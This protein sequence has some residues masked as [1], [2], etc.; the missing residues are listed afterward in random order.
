MAQGGGKATSDPA[1]VQEALWPVARVPVAPSPAVSPALLQSFTNTLAP[2]G[3]FSQMEHSLYWRR[4]G[5]FPDYCHPGNLGARVQFKPRRLQGRACYR[6]V[7]HPDAEGVQ[8]VHA[9]PTALQQLPRPLFGAG[10]EG[11]TLSV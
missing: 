6:P 8:P 4:L 3:E 11:F 9:R 7:D 1:P 2:V 10:H 5:V